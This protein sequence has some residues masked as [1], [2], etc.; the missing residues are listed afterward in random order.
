MNYID[1]KDQK[2]LQQTVEFLN[3]RYKANFHLQ[4]TGQYTSHCPVHSEG[5]ASFRSY[6]KKGQVM[7]SI[8]IFVEI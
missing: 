3:K 5:E 8:P 2:Y 1:M 4:P 7:E 6:I